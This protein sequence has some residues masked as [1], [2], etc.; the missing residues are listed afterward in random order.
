M[1]TR[2]ERTLELDAPA[3]RLVSRLMEWAKWSGFSCTE[4]GPERWVFRRGS[5]WRAWF[6]RDV[7]VLPTRAVVEVVDEHPLTVRASVAM[8][9]GNR[10]ST[11]AQ[12]QAEVGEQVGRL[13]AYLRGVYDFESLA[14]ETG[15]A[16][17][18]PA[19]QKDE[20]IVELDAPAARLEPRLMEW[21]RSSGFVCTERGPERWAFRRGST[22]RAWLSWDVE[23]LPSRAMVEVV[24]ERPLTVRASVEVDFGNRMS[25]PAQNEAEVGEQTGRLVAY[26]RG[27]Y[28]FWTP[29]PGSE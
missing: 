29:S 23:V 2:V 17:A 9:L 4:R 20:R 16:Q 5:F 12:D 19:V 21:A 1:D 13:A 25:T 18:A 14:A 6:S 22:W 24:R 10:M 15:R 27:V 11:A 26:L 3:E 7:E 28:D 8:D